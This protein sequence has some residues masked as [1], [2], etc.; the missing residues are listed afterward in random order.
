[1]EGLH[2]EIEDII[3]A[4][5][6]KPWVTDLYKL[7]NN[8]SSISF[9]QKGSYLSQGSTLHVVDGLQGGNEDVLSN[10][11]KEQFVDSLIE[12]LGCYVESCDKQC[13]GKYLDRA[14]DAARRTGANIELNTSPKKAAFSAKSFLE[15]WKVA[16]PYLMDFDHTIDIAPRAR[17]FRRTMSLQVKTAPDPEMPQPSSTTPK[18]GGTVKKRSRK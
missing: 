17:S 6:Q 16:T 15:L 14:F 4:T 11:S 12:N 3:L 5:K 2:K 7:R 10:M 13:S 9:Q 18:S 8:V 1:V